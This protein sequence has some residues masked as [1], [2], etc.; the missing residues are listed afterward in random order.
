[1]SSK[2]KLYDIYRFSFAKLLEYGTIDKQNGILIVDKLCNENA[3]DRKGSCQLFV[4]TLKA[5]NISDNPATFKKIFVNIDFSDFVKNNGNI[6]E[7]LAKIPNGI[8]LY[9]DKEE[10][11]FLDFH[12]S[13]SMS[14]KSCVYY[15]NEKYKSIIEPRITFNMNKG[16]VILS[17]WQAYAGLSISDATILEGFKLSEDEVVIIPDDEQV[18]YVECVTAISAPLLITI[19]NTLKDN[20]NKLIIPSHNN[21]NFNEFINSLKDTKSKEKDK[22]I[23][24]FKKIKSYVSSKDF[25]R[26][27]SIDSKQNKINFNK[28]HI[29]KILDNFIDFENQQIRELLD[30]I[31]EI[32]K[33]YTDFEKMEQEDAIAN[34]YPFKDKVVYWE[35]FHVYDYPITINKFDG[36][37]LIDLKYAKQIND[38]LSETEINYS[39]EDAID[40]LDSLDFDEKYDIQ[41]GYSYQIRLP[42]I[43]GMVHACDF[44]KFFQEHN[45]NFIYGN[46]YDDTI[47]YKKYD[48]NKIKLILTES[49]FKASRV[50]K[51]IDKLKNETHI[52][53]F[54]R[55]M[56]EYDYELAISN[57]VPKEDNN[58]NLNYQFVSTLPFDHDELNNLINDNKKA[59]EIATSDHGLAKKIC[60]ANTNEKSIYKSNSDFYFSTKKFIEQKNKE[61]LSLSKRLLRIKIESPGYRKIICAD[62]L[63]LLYFSVHHLSREKYNLP[64]LSKNEFYAPNTLLKNIDKCILLRN[65]HYSRNEIGVLSPINDEKDDER[66]KYFKHLSGIIMVNPLSLVAERLGGADYDGDQIVLIANKNLEKTINNLLD[67]NNNFKYPVIIIP[68]TQ[69]SRVDYNYLNVITCF[70]NTFSSKVGLISNNAFHK[71]FIEY[72]NDNNDKDEKM[73]IYTIL[74]GLEIDSAKKGVKPYLI[75]TSDNK[76]AKLFLDFNK[77]LDEINPNLILFKNKI[78]ANKDEHVLFKVANDIYSF[79]ETNPQYELTKHSSLRDKVTEIDDDLL[80]AFAIKHIYNNFN[81]KINN[82]NAYLFKHK[83]KNQ[84]SSSIFDNINHILYKKGVSDYKDQ[85]FNALGSENPTSTL[86]TYAKSKIKFHYLFDVDERKDFIKYKLG[87]SNIPA[88]I[89][90]ILCDFSNDGCYL[91]YLELLFIKMIDSEYAA[92]IAKYYGEFIKNTRLDRKNMLKYN[93]NIS[94]KEFYYV[95]KYIKEIKELF[96]QQLNFN[97]KLTYR[98]NIEKSKQELYTI[99]QNEANQLK[100][101]SCLS[102]IENLSEDSIVFDVFDNKIL[103]ALLEDEVIIDG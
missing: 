39:N 86:S 44:K 32:L 52:S 43:K 61:I 50:I 42:F 27:K 82:I 102:L 100:Y 12:K 75:K 18:S 57:L 88:E 46:T 63:D 103:T 85:I 83:I 31:N 41:K 4:Q 91:L 79:I 33:E 24:Y 23:Y 55:I 74:S 10:I 59:Y 60:R 73:P 95:T 62:L 45:I 5:L 38:Y 99:L 35:K 20:L 7:E 96:A 94:A 49:Q 70:D 51:N 47:P 28:K 25:T 72:A 19:L 9:I 36:Q 48:I 53:A 37:G 81:I 15:I 97:E 66:I 29:A 16:K 2:K 65:P 13:N 1:M 64:I 22:V 30:I 11:H 98:Q 92:N 71:S 21:L 34:S 6:T 84:R 78:A 89:L 93:S 76:L 14:K 69:S 3:I 56:N 87:F 67:E 101:Q 40:D 68:N 17:K 80:K 54:F 26:I 77:H 58:V 90:D 8:K